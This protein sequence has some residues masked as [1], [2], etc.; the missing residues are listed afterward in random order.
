MD[1]CIFCDTPTAE[2]VTKIDKINGALYKS[3]CYRCKNCGEEWETGNML[4]ENL[5]KAKEAIKAKM[6]KTFPKIEEIID[7]CLE[8]ID[9]EDENT[10]AT[11]DIEDLIELRD[12]WA[13]REATEIDL[14][15]VLE[16]N[17][18]LKKD[19]KEISDE[20]HT[21]VAKLVTMINMMTEDIAHNGFDEDV[22]RA[23]KDEARTWEC[24]DDKNCA[25]CVYRYY[26]KKAN[27]KMWED[28]NVFGK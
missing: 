16:K 18:Q 26:E 17:E 28:K 14:D 10:Y 8:E 27:K 2:I 15:M 21:D 4:D 19:I 6:K 22:C 23:F 5:K 11:L 9:Q 20:W 3:T 25:K 1:K 13:S 7:L 24:D 12:L